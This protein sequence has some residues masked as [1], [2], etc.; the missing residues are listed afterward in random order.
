MGVIAGTLLVIMPIYSYTPQLGMIIVTVLI[1]FLFTRN[2]ALSMLIATLAL[3][4]LFWLGGTH[5]GMLVLWSVTIA[6]IVAIKFLPTAL[7]AISK[8]KNFKDYIKGH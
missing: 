4:F 8:N 7:K 5:S 6:I 1:P 3:P 2:V